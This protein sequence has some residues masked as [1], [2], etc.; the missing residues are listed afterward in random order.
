MAR[1]L[2]VRSETI[3]APDKPEVM[4][5]ASNPLRTTLRSLYAD[6]TMRRALGLL[7]ALT[8]ITQSASAG[9]NSHRAK[10]SGGSTPA[11]VVG[12]EGIFDSTEE[13]QLIFKYKVRVKGNTGSFPDGVF[14]LPYAK[15]NKL[16]YGQTK[17][18]R[19]GQTI[20]L[21]AVAGVGGLLLLLSKSHTH[22]VSVDYTDE[23]NHEQTITFEVGKDAIRPLINSLE[24]RTGKKFEHESGPLA[25]A[26]SKP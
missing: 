8:L 15:I 9:V 25:S 2:R 6:P 13:A 21:S 18:L 12:S 20:A 26:P 1:N 22:Y 23:S 3:G 5:T 11:P 24:V 7:L 10:V 4:R 17:N 19:V 16:I 14:E